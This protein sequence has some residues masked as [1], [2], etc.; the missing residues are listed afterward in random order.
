MGIFAGSLA[1]VLFSRT[2]QRVLGVLY[3][4]PDRSFFAN[5]VVRLAA[6]GT[7]AAHRELE[8]LT[9]AG[10]LV[11]H[12]VGNQRHFQANRV[13]P[14]YDELRGIVLKTFG[15]VDVLREALAPFAW[16]IRLA[17]VYGS[18][19]RRE[20]TAGSDIDLLL[21]TDQLSYTDLFEGLAEA[22][23]RLGR[24][25]KPTLYKTDELEAKLVAGNAFVSR[26]LAQPKLFV[27]GT[28]NDLPEP[29][30]PG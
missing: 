23:K 12:R 30:Q 19:A 8:R 28:E 15:L 29:A 13:A 22:E 14:I 4:Q 24:P 11:E 6:V 7:G 26:V 21:V 27:V 18:V 1:D 3:G 16:R 9:G 25:V 10:L 5:E 17:F 2:Q 20:D